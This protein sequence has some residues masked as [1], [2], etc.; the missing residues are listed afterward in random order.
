MD[1]QRLYLLFHVSV[2]EFKQLLSSEKLMGMN[3]QIYLH[4][5]ENPDTSYFKYPLLRLIQ[6]K[7]EIEAKSKDSPVVIKRP[8]FL[9]SGIEFL[10]I[11]RT[12]AS[13]MVFRRQT[14]IIP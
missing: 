12:P 3:I 14:G 4:N 1:N 10:S 7:N 11:R 8:I 2:L 13:I 9:L 6:G 5:D